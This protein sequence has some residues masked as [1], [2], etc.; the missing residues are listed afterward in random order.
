MLFLPLNPGDEPC[1]G[2]IGSLTI[3]T[4]LGFGDGV[5]LLLPSQPKILSLAAAYRASLSCNDSCGAAV[6]EFCEGDELCG[7]LRMRNAGWNAAAGGGTTELVREGSRVGIGA[8]T[9]VFL[10]QCRPQSQK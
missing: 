4:L 5:E 8:A 1:S 9:P 2:A 6:G 7:R 10:V 3:L